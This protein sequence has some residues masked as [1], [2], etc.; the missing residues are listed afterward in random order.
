MQNEA[1]SL[2]EN[3]PVN[4]G[5]ITGNRDDAARMLAAF[6]AHMNKTGKI[7]LKPWHWRRFCNLF[8]AVYEPP[9]LSSWW[10]ISTR[11]KKELF[12]KQLEYLA[13]RTNRFTSACEYLARL[14]E[15]HWLIIR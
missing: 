3:N 5:N 9:W 7:C 11:D 2:Q 13:L 8:K 14:D 1:L 10:D 15:E 12:F 6:Q 4:A